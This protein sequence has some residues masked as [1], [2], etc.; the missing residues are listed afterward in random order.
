MW[1]FSRYS[2]GWKCGL[3]ADWTELTHCVDNVMDEAEGKS[4]KRRYFYITLLREPI[5]RF[6]SEWRH[7]RRGA[8]WRTSRHM[9]GG[10]T[11]SPEE[12]EPC[13]SGPDWKDV[14]IDEFLSCPHNLAMN[15][16]TRM[17]ADL[18]L[19][20]CYNRS[21]MTPEERDVLMLA[22]A[23]ENLRKTAFFGVCENQSVSQYLFESTFRL[24][25]RKPL[26]QLNQTRS[27]LVLS[28]LT[29]ADLQRIRRLNHL[30]VQLYEFAVRLLTERFNQMRDSDPQFEQHFD[31]L[32]PRFWELD[33]ADV[34]LIRRIGKEQKV[35]KDD[36]M[37]ADPVPS[38]DS[39]RI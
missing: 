15:R 34:R 24:F 2:I 14:S 38:P 33:D 30:D 36:A 7:V 9:C 16:Q 10:R 26:I 23:K 6:V 21:V 17:L 19:V 37:D 1:L 12:L 32:S 27:S 8:T 11:P 20:G 28:G 35:V 22:S 31:R 4:V 5:A 25:F 18:S 39:H 29:H 13:Y 3:H